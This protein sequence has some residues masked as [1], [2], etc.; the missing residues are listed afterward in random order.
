MFKANKLRRQQAVRQHRYIQFHSHFQLSSIEVSNGTMAHHLWIVLGGKG[1]RRQ[2]DNAR[3]EVQCKCK[4]MRDVIPDPPQGHTHRTTVQ[5]NC[6]L[7]AIKAER[8]DKSH[9]NHSSPL[10]T[11]YPTLPEVIAN[12]SL[13]LPNLTFESHIARLGLMDI[14]GH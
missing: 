10:P 4:Q 8:G 5:S 6:I 9:H 3:A 11:M 12:F 7:H 13:T 14:K 2:G 1:A